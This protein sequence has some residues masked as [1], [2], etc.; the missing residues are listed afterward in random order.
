MALVVSWALRYGSTVMLMLANISMTVLR[1]CP[2]KRF[3]LNLRRIAQKY[4]SKTELILCR[5]RDFYGK[6]GYG[7]S[8]SSRSTSDAKNV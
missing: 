8:K 6:T 3:E 4:S 1:V 7:T 2:K 5:N